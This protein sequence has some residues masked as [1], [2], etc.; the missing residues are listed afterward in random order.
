MFEGSEGVHGSIRLVGQ[1]KVTFHGGGLGGSAD[2]PTPDV[3]GA[4]GPSAPPL[5]SPARLPFPMVVIPQEIQSPP[6]SVQAAYFR[7]QGKVCLKGPKVC[8][9][10]SVPCGCVSTEFEP[11]SL[12]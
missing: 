3:E 10:Q 1:V 6:R 7:R 4:G 12:I 5:V 8:K 9:G 11:N 2:S